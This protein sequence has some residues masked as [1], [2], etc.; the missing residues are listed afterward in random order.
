MGNPYRKVCPKS[1]ISKEMQITNHYELS[2][3]TCLHGNHQKEK[4]AKVT[5]VDEDTEKFKHITTDGHL[6]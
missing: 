6:Q 1:Q 5:R 3:Q 2:A 4:I